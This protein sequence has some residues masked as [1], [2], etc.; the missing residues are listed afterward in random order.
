MCN[1]EIVIGN[2]PFLHT[3]I[4]V[5]FIYDP[6]K[7]AS[8]S[9]L[10]LLFQT[11]S[12]CID[13]KEPVVIIGDFNFDIQDND[14]LNNFFSTTYSL[15][16]LIVQPTTDYGTILDHVYTNIATEKIS[17]SGTLESYYSDHKPVFIIIAENN[18]LR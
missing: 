15:K 1:I 8:L 13:L 3:R 16:Q 11:L 5:C 18:S 4:H 2:V 12:T 9:K 6:P 14:I 7:E 10:K 17:L